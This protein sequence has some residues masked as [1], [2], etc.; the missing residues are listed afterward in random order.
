MLPDEEIGAVACVDGRGSCSMA[1][2]SA[3]PAL[4]QLL[5]DGGRRSES[6]YPGRL[7][8]T[9][10]LS[11]APPVA[12]QEAPAGHEPSPC[13]CTISLGA[14]TMSAAS[15]WPTVYRSVSERSGHHPGTNGKL[16]HRLQRPVAGYVFCLLH[17]LSRH[18]RDGCTAVLDV[19]W[20]FSAARK[21]CCL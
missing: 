15:R 8:F 16:V 4:Q 18:R 5:D 9:T 12:S 11:S 7:K 17:R 1:S 20:E 10:Q 19:Q 21:S 6:E 14:L 13:S 3:S 2:I